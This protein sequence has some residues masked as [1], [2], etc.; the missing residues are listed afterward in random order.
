MGNAPTVAEHST[1]PPARA[2]GGERAGGER[3]RADDGFARFDK[4]LL[5]D[6][7]WASCFVSLRAPADPVLR[8][9]R[10]ADRSP[11]QAARHN[12]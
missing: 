7:V 11:Q 9:R 4:E 10:A 1:D 6:I 2:T 12:K 8:P 3:N 5:D